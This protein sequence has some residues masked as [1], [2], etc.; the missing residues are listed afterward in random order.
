MANVD[1]MT[2]KRVVEECE[3]IL[4]AAM[5]KIEREFIEKIYAEVY[6]RQK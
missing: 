4:L 2:V 1:D 3:A 5:M 6:G